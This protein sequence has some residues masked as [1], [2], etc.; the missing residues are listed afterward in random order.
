MGGSL[1]DCLD[2]ILRT[3]LM[4]ESEFSRLM[5]DSFATFVRSSRDQSRSSV[6]W[7]GNIQTAETQ[8]ETMT[9]IVDS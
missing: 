2:D 8:T 7:S 9:T 6:N 3:A 5:R 4:Y 1:G